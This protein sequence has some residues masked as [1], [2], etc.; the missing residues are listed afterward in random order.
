MSKKKKTGLDEVY[1]INEIDWTKFP[2]SKDPAHPMDPQQRKGPVQQQAQKEEW[3]Q[4]DEEYVE[5]LGALPPHEDEGDYISWKPSDGRYGGEVLMFVPDSPQDAHFW[6]KEGEE[7]LTD[8]SS[9][10]W[11]ELDNAFPPIFGK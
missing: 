2:T 7:W 6:T 5:D 3:D 4:V 1:K 11:L 10:E 8:T 9:K